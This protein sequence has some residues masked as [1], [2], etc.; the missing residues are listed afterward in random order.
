MLIDGHRQFR[1]IHAKEQ[2]EPRMASLRSAL[3][4]SI[5]LLIGC[6]SRTGV[7]THTFAAADVDGAEVYLR[8]SNECFWLETQD[9]IKFTAVWPQGYSAQPG[10]PMILVDELGRTIA[11]EG[12]F[13]SLG[14]TRRSDFVADRCLI[15][16]STML[17]GSVAEVNGKPWVTPHPSQPPNNPQPQV[18]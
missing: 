7:P 12:D 3:F 10:P 8:V 14:V 11:K 15:G 2:D 17:V 6:T 4:V 1:Q 16:T 9:G 18:R 5:A 13:L